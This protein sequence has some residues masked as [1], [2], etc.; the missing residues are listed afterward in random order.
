MRDRLVQTL[1]RRERMLHIRQLQE[2]QAQQALAVVLRQEEQLKEEKA[3]AQ[4]I[5]FQAQQRIAERFRRPG[6]TIA[7]EEL[8][9]HRNQILTAQLLEQEIEAAIQALQPEIQRRRQEVVRR[10]QLRRM[11]EV[12]TEKTRNLLRQEDQRIEQAGLDDLVAQRFA[13]DALSSE[14]GDGSTP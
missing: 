10:H 6:E 12:L 3:R 14:N 11:M 8:L 5:Q 13:V 4:A 9:L 2:D 7:S 1:R